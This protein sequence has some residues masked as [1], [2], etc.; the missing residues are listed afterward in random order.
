MR[1]AQTDKGSQP[2]RN[3]ILNPAWEASSSVQTVR[4][5]LS[6]NPGFEASTGQ[7]TIRTNLCT[8]PRMTNASFGGYGTQTLAG[9][10][11]I[12]THPDGITTAVR[13][14]Y[15]SGD[16]NPGAIFMPLPASSTQYTVS[17]WV[18]QE[19]APAGTT[20]AIALKGQSSSA[21]TSTSVGV[22][23]RLTWT[24]T[25]AAGLVVG[26]DFGVRAAGTATGTGSF[27]VTGV[28]AETAPNTVSFF[29]GGTAAAGDFTYG[30]NGAANA[31]SSWQR[32]TNA[33][34]WVAATNAGVYQT[35]SSPFAGTKSC[36]VVTKG[37]SGDGTFSSGIT[38][39]VGTTYTSSIWV[40]VTSAH[41]F[42]G[43]IRFMDGAG[44][45]VIDSVADLTTSVVIGSW[46]RVSVTATAPTNTA[47]MMMIWRILASHT[48]TTFYVDGSML[49]ASPVMGTYF[50]GGT[51]ATGDYSYIWTGT[52]Q[53]S[54]SAQRATSAQTAAGTGCVGVSSGDWSASGSK[55]LRIVPTSATSSTDTFVAVSGDTGGFRL[56]MGPGKTYTALATYNQKEVLTGSLRA[57][58]PSAIRVFWRRADGVYISADSNAKVNA[59]GVET[60]R[61]TVTLPL[62]STEAFIRLYHGGRAG[63]GDV[64]VDNF[65]LVEGAYTGDYVDGT[66]PFSKWDGTA[67]A[68]TSVGYP[69]QLW[70]IAGK[71]DVDLIGVATTGASSIPVAPFDARTIYAAYEIKGNTSSYN[72][73]AYYG[74]VA[75]KGFALQTAASGSNAMA[76]RFDFPG[77]TANGA[78]VHSNG[79]TSARHVAAFAFNQGLTAATSCADG[80]ADVTTVINP[81]TT[82]WD[83]G[84][85]YT[86]GG[87]SEFQP[88]RVLVYYANHDRATR[89]A[90]SRYLGTKYGANV[91]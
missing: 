12:P 56:G 77:G 32:G 80:A 50:D 91:A 49:E 74:V 1:R 46:V 37:A 31:S 11:G 55:S 71:P 3:L 66:K 24:M 83:D 79:R 8:N 6:L 14:S 60:L 5:N 20:I 57:T 72:I 23:E 68:S 36:A 2:V 76:N 51:A 41:N 13:V 75:S 29:D 69:Q 22:W 90:I 48:P 10:S 85:T 21:A 53:Q 35:S 65:M 39:T 58:N 9:I 45:T 38:A 4:T 67:N 73:A 52:A 88:L 61:V 40:K 28:M 84:R 70:D 25:T 44:A 78:I 27:L 54:A 15:N 18:Y 62:D 19:T 7:T 16:A 43:V 89:L 33:Q 17:A 30:W 87:A 26:N 86:N 82:G 64:Y 81:G 42:S 59:I 47:S 34:F 63:A